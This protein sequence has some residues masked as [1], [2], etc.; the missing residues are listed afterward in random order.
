V[1]EARVV[2]GAASRV[3]VSVHVGPED[4]GIVLRDYE[5]EEW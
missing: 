3:R 2:A 5:T 1:V 4:E